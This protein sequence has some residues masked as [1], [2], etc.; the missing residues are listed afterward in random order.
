MSKRPPP[1]ALPLA[2]P[3]LTRNEA[4]GRS[5]IAQQVHQ[6]ELTL[7]DTVWSLSLQPL[8]NDAASGFG[9]D[10][11]VV[12]AD[13]AGA[14]FELRLAASAAEH[15]LR[16]RFDAPDLPAQ[17]P[18]PL[19]EA[20]RAAA[21]EAAL[22]DAMDALQA[23][24]QGAVRVDGVMQA[25][26]LVP[27]VT[28]ATGP[29]H[30]FGL[31]LAS[32]SARLW[33]TLKTDALGLML[34][35]GLAAHCSAP[36][37]CVAMD[38]L[39]LLLRAEVGTA[40]L[41]CAE[42]R[43]LRPGDAVMLT[44]SFMDDAGQIWLGD[45]GWGLRARADGGRLVVTQPLHMTEVQMR[46]DIDDAGP[47]GTVR[48][49]QG[50]EAVALDALPVRLHFDLG[51]RTMPLAE[52]SGLQVGQV[53]D[54]GRPLS[55]AVSIRANGALIGTGELMEIGGRIAVGITSLGPTHGAAE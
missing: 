28:P 52:V 53:L 3:R 18:A 39:P 41:S 36:R 43:S 27:H 19:P 46:D 55:Q 17:L 44:H 7:G 54:L 31:S 33:G 2:V 37:G 50:D 45:G 25:G 42:L 12:N 21:L 47:R 40:A 8:A 10:D 51:Q 34:M 26:E 4:E 11:W 16:A 22:Q 1:L 49:T 5:L 13:W 24:G 32:G 48:G 35:A 30:A 14:P 20:L 38:S 6:R 15:W 23:T 9:A 29:S